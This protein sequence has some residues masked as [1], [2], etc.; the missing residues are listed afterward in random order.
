MKA[1]I[2]TEY[3]KPLDIGD[4]DLAP[5]QAHEVQV[6][7]KATGVCHSDLSVQKGNLPFP[8]PCVLGHEAA[9]V[10]EAVG[11]G[12]TNVEPGDHVVV[13]WTPMCGDCYFCRRGQTHLCEAGQAI[14]LMEDGTSRLS[15]NGEMLF[16]GVNA[17][18]FAESVVLRD[19]SVVKIPE[20]VPFEIAA[21]VGCGVLTGVGAAIHTAD[22]QPGEAT[23]VLGCGGVG[24]NV[25]QGA[26]LA[27]AHPIIAIDA[28]APKL[29]M[30]QRFGATHTIDASGSDPATE[31]QALTEGRGAD[32]A[33]EVVGNT[34][35]QRQV[36]DM[37]RRGGK[38]VL[39]GVAPLTD[40]V[41]LPA[42][43]FTLQERHVHG[44]YYGACDPKRDVV[45]F[46][47]LWKGGKLDLDGLISQKMALDDVNQ[48][49]E[50]MEEGKVIRTVL[51]L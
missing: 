37:T 33:F 2:C 40:E 39:V 26:K 19:N 34:G 41:S 44:C 49:F 17:A 32:V 1:A 12:V 45:R 23:V 3:G 14:G 18:T 15:R 43:F 4:V 35:L 48:A 22:V 16:H 11:D 29:E 25:I 46:L 5:P 8:V 24:I 9:G 7:I 28:K 47:E 50:D 30:A 51:T 38:T 21:V 13:M 36:F 6:Q 42:A 20:D 31:V 10:V 27:G